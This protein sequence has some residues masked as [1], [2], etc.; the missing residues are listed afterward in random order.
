LMES[1]GREGWLARD[2]RRPVG[3]GP[4]VGETKGGVCLAVRGRGIGA[5]V[6]YSTRAGAERV[7]PLAIGPWHKC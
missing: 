2:G 3:S 7:A 4:P 6:G 5:L 1:R